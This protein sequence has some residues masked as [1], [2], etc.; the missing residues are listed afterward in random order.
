MAAGKGRGTGEAASGSGARLRH[1]ATLAVIVVLSFGIVYSLTHYLPLLSFVENWVGDY[2]M[3]TQLPVQP[4]DP[5]IL[6]LGIND[7]TLQKFP[8]RSPV[9]RGFLADVLQQVA[10]RGAKAV[11]LDILFDQPSEPAKDAALKAVIDH[12]PIPLVISYALQFDGGKDPHAVHT[13]EQDYASSG[14]QHQTDQQAAYIAQ[15]V[16]PPDRGFA[17]LDKDAADATVR[18]IYPGRPLVTGEFVPGFAVAL[19]EK[20]GAPL[21]ADRT[22]ELP[23]VWRMPPALNTP[24]F[25][26]LPAQAAK[27]A[28]LPWIKNK[29]VL[30]GLTVTGDD[31]HR[32]PFSV[33]QSGEKALMPGVLVHAHSLSQLLDQREFATASPWQANLLVLTFAILG[34]VVALLDRGLA[35][36]LAVLAV[37]L[38]AVWIGGWELVRWQIILLPLVAPSL[39]LATSLG[40]GNFYVTSHERQQKRFIRQAMSRHVSPAYVEQLV[41]NPELLALGSERREMSFI[42]TDIAGFTTFA[43]TIDPQVMAT[44]LNAYL[45]GVCNVVFQQGGTVANFI[46][47]AVFAVFGAPVPQ[48]DH[49][50]RAVETAAAIDVFAEDYRK[51]VNAAGVP[52]GH[53]RIGVHTATALV[54]NFGG[55]HQQYT[56]MGDAVNTAARLEGLNKYIGTRILMSMATAEQSGRPFRPVGDIVLK[57]KTEALPVAEPVA[58]QW[59]GSAYGGRYGEAYA[60]LARGDAGAMAAL[61]AL[62]RENPGDAPVRFHLDRLREGDPVT[63]RVTMDDK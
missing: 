55:E 49:A 7:D 4:V 14:Q 27:V 43:E 32:T 9:D 26:I 48:P 13:A 58:P 17:N 62:A 12:Y 41:Q 16:P 22:V 21:P 11:G 50:R 38:V 30:I 15:F 46:G 5:D 42:F 10:A 45:D 35:T 28:P 31:T 47:D 52:L 23:L 29:I 33:I 20:V 3:V 6:V 8:Y 39:A 34:L 60:M 53:T 19:A 18:R 61:E 56:A 24:S 1:G 36:K 37:L 2:R 63:V 54:G 57:G 44:T 25:H 51:K 59:P 40:I